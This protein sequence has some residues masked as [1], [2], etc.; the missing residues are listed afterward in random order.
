M[1][2]TTL[3][4]DVIVPLALPNLYT[5]RVPHEWNDHIKVGQRTVVQFGKS[6]LYTAIIR[7]VHEKAPAEYQAKYLNSLLDDQ[8][9]VNELQLQFWEWISQYYM[10]NIGDVL[11]AALPSALKLSSE[12]IIS[13]H[14]EFS[15]EISELNEDETKIVD[16]LTTEES[17][18]VSD[19]E[20][21]LGKKTV[22]PI[23]RD[24]I[25]K[26][27][28]FKHEEIKEK[29]K[30]KYV[31]YVR[32]TEAMEDEARL[33]EAFDGIEKA[34]KQLELLMAFVH[35]SNQFE[36]TRKEIRKKALLEHVKASPAVLDALQKKGI[37]DVY[38][39]EIGRLSF[40][41]GSA[42]R[43]FELSEEQSKAMSEIKT[44][45]EDKNVV[46]LHG[47][48]SSGKTEIYIRLIE[49]TLAQGKQVLYLLPEIALTTQ[50]INR[51]QKSFGDKVGIYHSR[52]NDNERVEVWN[53]VLDNGNGENKQKPYQIV[54]GARSAVFIPFENLGLVI[55]DEEHENSFKQY[56]PAP[57][58]NG[59]DAAIYLA[60]MHGAKTLLGSATPAVESYFNA[61]T[62]K[63]G[64]VELTARY[65]G[66][67][68]PEVVILDL[69][70]ARKRKRLKNHL[71]QFLVENIE[72]T[73]AER[74]QVILF[75]NRRGYSPYLQCNTCAWVPQ[76][77][78]CD[79]SL[80]YHKDFND[81]RCHYCGYTMNVPHSCVACGSHDVRSRGFGTEQIEEE[82]E[83]YFP[84]AKVARMDLDT[85]RGKHGYQQIISDFEDQE[86][87]IL[88]GTQMVT[89]GLDFDHVGLVGIVSADQMLNYPDF[90]AFERSYQL[91]AQVSGRAGR[92]KKQGK[93]II[94]TSHPDHFIVE[95][96]AFNRYHEMYKHELYQRSNFHYPPYYRLI[97]ITLK[98][99]SLDV[100]NPT[101][102][103]FADA[104]KRKF[105]KRV[106]GPEFPLIARIRNFYHKDILIKLEKEA[107]PKAAKDMLQEIL[108]E[109]NTNGKF[110]QV[111]VH[112]DVDPM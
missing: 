63:Y 12:T 21:I 94:Q 76:C 18:K 101:A 9:V 17:L 43:E 57:R 108:H 70:E 3:F 49:E 5:Y 39:K 16:S 61:E 67:Q 34:P 109:F 59:R 91:M 79:I 106:L 36:K 32:L 41:E 85:T 28:I 111:I 58:Y 105:G 20:K 95:A 37:L 8:P 23:I 89:K 78:N 68:M 75:Q 50:I 112:V 14:H 40:P 47:V 26:Q 97:I 60:Q 51:L 13:L 10:C 102:K 69:K 66:M 54:L 77:K 25:N 24:L 96:V 64:L 35:L 2:R 88:V 93:V 4:V 38:E 27:V 81:L 83:L 82:L 15:G 65:R 33:K 98:H 56:D 42:I 87:D 48:T 30:P 104:C 1:S 19:V 29:Y 74:E 92:K 71:S 72:K 99:K 62:G 11:N 52:M 55:V 73:L 100:L 44:H 103:D 46:L 6:K 53:R 45:F 86:I 90:R 7:R 22:Y 80:T 110:K 107:S 84:L 31:A